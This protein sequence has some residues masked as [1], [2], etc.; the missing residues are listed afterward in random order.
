MRRWPLD[1]ATVLSDT[2]VIDRRP[3]LRELVWTKSTHV[4]YDTLVSTVC[5]LLCRRPSVP[6]A[7]RCVSPR[8]IR[9]VCGCRASRCVMSLA[10]PR[11]CTPATSTMSCD[12]TRSLYWACVR[13]WRPEWRPEVYYVAYRSSI[14]YCSVRSR[15]FVCLRVRPLVLPVGMDQDSIDRAVTNKDSSLPFLH[16]GDFLLIPLAY[17]V[18]DNC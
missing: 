1:K 17:P 4:P 13:L 16:S 6:A 8:I 10:L 18:I 7:T 12:S 2:S 5:R 3:R 15:A 14:V 11:S 9:G